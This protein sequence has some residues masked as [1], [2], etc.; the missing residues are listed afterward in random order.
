MVM[1][2]KE[3]EGID[4]F[5]NFDPKYIDWEDYFM[6]IHIPGLLKYVFNK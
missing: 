6:N 1:R 4:A 2:E 5:Y 3:A